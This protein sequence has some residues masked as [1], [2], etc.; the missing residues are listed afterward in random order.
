MIG[1]CLPLSGVRHRWNPVALKVPLPATMRAGRGAASWTAATGPRARA[2]GARTARRLA[3]LIAEL[4][5]PDPADRPASAAGVLAALDESMPPSAAGE[6]C[7]PSWASPARF[8][9]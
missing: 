9:R 2:L 5:E 3:R 4:M 1:A 7:W 8:G 6:R